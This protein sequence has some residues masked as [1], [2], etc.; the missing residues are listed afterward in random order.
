MI[1][2]D[3]EF[4]ESTRILMLKGAEIILTPNACNLDD[5][6]LYQFRTHAFENAVVTA[7]TNYSA[8]KDGHRFN[9]HSA[10]YDAGGKKILLA[11]KREGVFVGSIN[12]DDLRHYRRETIWGNAYR[13][14][15]IYKLL[16]SPAKE[17]IFIRKDTIGK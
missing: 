15:Q 7:M 5:L 1:C 2:Y 9:G 10:M 4:P 13:R 14:P 8:G 6:R 16:T 11:G 12:I 3:R 17:K